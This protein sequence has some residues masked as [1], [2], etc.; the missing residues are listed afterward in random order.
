M[1]W[2]DDSQGVGQE[3]RRKRVEAAVAEWA[4]Q[5]IDLTGRN[6]LL[7]YRTLKRGTLELTR[8]EAPALNALL[9]GKAVKI[10]QL[11]PPTESDPDRLDQALRRARAVHS[12]GR[13]W[14]EERG[15]DT[16]F[17]AVGMATWSTSTS[18][19]TP[20]APV[21][22]RS[23][24]FESKG[25]A[26]VEFEVRLDGEWAINET[27]LHLLETEFDVRPDVA[28]IASML[29][30]VDSA[31]DPSVVFQWL[32]QSSRTIPGF[33]VLD[34]VVAGTFAYTKLPMVKDLQS[35]VEALIDHELISAIA[36]DPAAR[37]AVKDLGLKET[38]PS[39]PDRTPP[40][41]EYLILDADASQN[42]AINAVLAG[43]P[44]IIQ[45]PPGTGKSQT[46]ANLIAAAAARGQRVLFVAEKRA[47]IEAVTKRLDAEGLGDLVMDLHGGV[48]SKRQFAADLSLTLETNSRIPEQSDLDLEHSLSSARDALSTHAAALHEAHDRWQ[49]SLYEVQ[50]R[51]LG[52]GASRDT[53]VR[54]STAVLAG[55]DAETA[56]G[57]RHQILEWSQLSE[58]LFTRK[59]PWTGAAVQTQEDVERAHAVLGELA[60]E[61]IP[62]A[63]AELDS[64]LA[65]TYLPAPQSIADWRRILSLLRRLSETSSRASMQL[66][67]H[68]L[69]Q[70][71]DNL[72]PSER[73][74][75]RRAAAS[76]FNSRYRTSK[77]VV[78]ELI[79]DGKRTG[80][81]QLHKLVADARVQLEE[82]R[83]LGGLAGPRLPDSL[84]SAGEAYDAL[85][86]GL[87]ALGAFV[88]TQ[89]FEQHSH[90]RVDQPVTSLIDDEAVLHR[91][92]RIHDLEEALR[93][94][95]LGELLDRIEAEGC[96]GQDAVKAF[97]YAWLSSIRAAII[98]GDHRLA[99]FSG[100][101]QNDRVQSFQLADRRHLKFNA[102]RVLR[103]VAEK[104]TAIRSEYTEQ[105]QLVRAE[106]KKKRRHITLRRLFEQAPDV[107]TALRP[108]WTMSPLVVSQTLPAAQVFDLVVFDEASQVLPA[109]AIP[110]LLR[111]PLAVV[112]GD[113]RQL[114]PT[115]FFD[116]TDDA[117]DDEEEGEDDGGIALTAGY[118]SVLDV[119]D[120]LVSSRM[121]QWHYRSEDERLIAFS[122][123]AIYDGLLTTFPGSSDSPCLDLDV[124]P[125]VLGREV[126]TR[127]S[128]AE[129]SRVVDL[130]I[131]HA[132]TR[133]DDTLGV[134]AMGSHH[135][136]RIEE[137]L[138]ER[139]RDEADRDLDEFFDETAE[140]RA[141]VKN[142]ERV[143]GDERD[144]IILSIGYGKKKDGTLLYR[145]GPLNHQGGE[146]RLNVA[147]TRARRRLTLVSS[148]SHHDM[149]P[150]RSSAKGVQLLHSYLKYVDSGGA[151][152]AGHEVENPLNPFEYD[153]KRR[154]EDA[155]LEV[156]PQYG[157]SGYRIDFAVR[158]P[159]ER[160]RFALAIEADGA[161]YHSAYTARDRDRLR[162]EAL[163]RMGWR[164]HRIWSTDWFNDPQ[165]ET[166]AA[167]AAFEAALRDDGVE[168]DVGFGAPSTVDD[169]HS[170]GAASVPD[171]SGRRPPIRRGQPITE[172]NHRQ[173]VALARWIMSDTL[174]RTDE[175]LFTEM[176]KELGYRRR[177][178]R[179]VDALNAAIASANGRG[180][181]VDY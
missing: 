38:D 21:L 71:V 5:L 64:I 79:G 88:A 145:F 139:L 155:G 174:L 80:A 33:E 164:F 68:D 120:A 40:A 93:N 143:Q 170:G 17:V 130:M 129:V 85:S 50:S 127:S 54:F 84:A 165:G 128:D 158:H 69:D 166:E 111:A 172:Y 161:S 20:Q 103:A 11:F 106:A 151:D 114:P 133:P 52:L 59:S 136:R 138:R 181:S 36:G 137:A 23:V 47:A 32:V 119:L 159:T 123:H 37:A 51:L 140:E 60:S 147:V 72:R 61:S 46:I 31:L 45:G 177:G 57:V 53:G 82:W 62:H 115:T 178:S 26:A 157:T 43:E 13:A 152:L 74:F 41:A 81:K 22:L 15:I 12:K 144:A 150:G 153:V 56:R 163:E 125:H 75:A 29:Q 19:A 104:S 10:S 2:E 73:G 4:R 160:D 135:A 83:A 108:C 67:D 131:E 126:D 98:A 173:L 171:R 63:R 14:F 169:F 30:D 27:L 97:D 6:Q 107:L 122:N 28:E 48:P 141:F 91:L 42:A 132:R 154:L 49:L 149:D 90:V 113:S 156:I 39:L 99:S 92:P 118:E 124:I 121:L 34:R 35:N 9:A 146:R 8:A 101:L 110:A 44:I 76:L 176:M 100:R 162:Q 70:L 24:T 116:S 58:P 109:D 18:S 134:I 78:R 94:L 95:A 16:L 175:E 179:I 77:S 1:P 7:Y 105:D 180:D 3:R 117:D 66:F 148:F 89:D 25:S 142:L 102:R 87:A 55:L 65:A 167:V 112:A 86:T 96:V 168:S